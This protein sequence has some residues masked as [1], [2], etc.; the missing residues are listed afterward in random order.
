MPWAMRQRPAPRNGTTGHPARPASRLDRGRRRKPPSMRRSP[1]PTW[2]RRS[3]FQPLQKQ[4][5]LRS[6]LR[7]QPAVPDLAMVGPQ[8]FQAIGDQGEHVLG[9]GSFEE[10]NRLRGLR[11][12]FGMPG[13]HR[14]RLGHPV[15]R[16][17]CH[18]HEFAIPGQ[19]ASMLRRV[20]GDQV[21]D[22]DDHP[23]VATKFHATF[24]TGSFC[25]DLIHSAIAQ[26][27][28]SM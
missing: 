13:D 12:Q 11:P 7:E 17:Q 26:K 28:P 9:V 25:S 4:D 15:F 6:Q 1:A 18:A 23:E 27:A 2:N 14:D 21:Q 3:I 19:F 22:L 20:L 8:T 16:R 24:H 5:L 10:G